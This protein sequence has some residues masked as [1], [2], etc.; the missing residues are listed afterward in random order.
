ME[1]G[2][3]LFIL[4]ENADTPAQVAGLLTAEGYGASTVVVLEH[5]GGPKQR[6]IEGVARGW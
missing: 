3:R 6:A 2:A 5:L 4:S 1:P